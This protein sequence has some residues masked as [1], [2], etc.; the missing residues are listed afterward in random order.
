MTAP[1]DSV[2]V[3]LVGAVG[4]MPSPGARNSRWFGLPVPTL[5]IL[6]TVRDA[7]S[8]DVT[9]VES[10]VRSS[11]HNTAAAPVTWGAAIEVPEMVLVAV[12]GDAFE[13]QVDVMLLPG[14]N[15]STQ[16]P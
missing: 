7:S 11:P 12:D 9:A 3:T 8:A 1:S 4:A 14:A 2:A 6:P 5:E 10:A 16:E 13:I 15:M